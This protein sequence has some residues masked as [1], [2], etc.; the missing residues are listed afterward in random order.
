[1][2]NRLIHETSPYLLQHADNPV[3]W[4]PWGSDAFAKSK[5]EDKPIFLSIGYSACHWCH[6]M[7]HESFESTDIANLMNQYFVNVK[8]DRE[9]RPDIDAI[10]MQAV[11]AQTGRGG[12]PMTV[13]LTPSG[14]PFFCGTYFPPEDRHGMPG[15]P[16]V[17]HG[18]SEAYQSRKADIEQSAD[19]LT[20]HI[21]SGVMTAQGNEPLTSEVLQRAYENLL[22][23]FD[24]T[25]GGFGDAPKFPQP[26]ALEFLLRYYLRSNQAEALDMVNLTL[27]KMARGGLY[28]QLGGGFHRYSTDPFW[29]VPHFEKMLYDNALL[30]RL[31]LHGYQITGSPAYQ[32][33]TEE[34]L[35]YVLREMTSPSGGFY[36]TQDAD[37][38]GQEGK[39]FIWTLDQIKNILGDTH[40]TSLFA[41]FYGITNEGNFDGSNILNIPFDFRETANHFSSTPEY[42]ATVIHEGRLTLL[43]HRQTRIAPGCDDK[44]IVSWN[45]LMLRS[46]AE[47]GATLQRADYIAAAATNAEFLL[48]SMRDPNGRLLRTYRNGTPKLNAYLEDYSYLIDGLLALH[49]ATFDMRWLHDATQLANQ[50]CDLFWDEREQTFYDTGKD[51]EELIVRPRDVFDNATPSGGAVAADT[52]LRLSIFTGNLEYNRKAATITR[53]IRTLMARVPLG[54]SHWLGALDFY[55]STPKEIAVIG[56]RNI[57]ATQALLNEIYSRYLPN[58]VVTGFNPE[59]AE[60]IDEIPLLEDKYISE[61][62]P[63]AFV[64]QNYACLLPATDPQTL[65]KQLDA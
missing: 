37:S 4:Y 35:D 32:R 6:V 8:V 47:A 57:P 5:L 56:A 12:W 62:N 22:Q 64:C 1:M 28:D 38:E 39:Y 17:L 44:I 46:F 10:Y 25:H 23:E 54:F 53:S 29:L 65:A 14:K 26:M 27:E 20:A 15:L 52:L 13:F 41:Y 58:K 61:G 36:S 59:E 19:Q 2:S 34:T 31:Y 3:D 33:V 60:G 30:S 7:A 45:G 42:L 11:Q 51:H 50:M 40:E 24:K 9:E 21:R 43:Q 49:E 48:D 16:R 18:V 63:S 55:L